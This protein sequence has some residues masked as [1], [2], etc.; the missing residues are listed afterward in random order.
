MCLKKTVFFLICVSLTNC[1]QKPNIVLILADDLGWNDVSYHGSNQIPTPNIDAL[2][3]N[4]IILDRFYTQPACTPS[5]AALLTGQYPI[6]TGF[7]G[8]VIHA[9]ENRYLPHDVKLLPEKL[10]DLGY[11]TN[12]IGKWHLGYAYRNVTPTYRGFDYHFGYWNGVIGYFD[13]IAEDEGLTGFDMRRN[14][15]VMWSTQNQYATELFTTKAK[16]VIMNHNETTP[17][18]LLVSHLAPHAGKRGVVYEVPDEAANNEKFWYI[19][20]DNRRKYA[21]MVDELDKSVGKIIQALFEKGILDNTIILF[22]SDNG[23]Q[24]VGPVQANSGSNWPFRGTKFTAF[25]GGI[26]N[27]AFMYYSRLKQKNVVYDGLMHITDV[28][29][30]LLGAI[31]EN[32]NDLKLD[33]INQWNTLMQNGESNRTEVLINIDEV[34]NWSGIIFDGLKLINGSGSFNQTLEG[35]YGDDGRNS[36]NPPYDPIKVLNSTANK[37]LNSNLTEALILQLRNKTD[38][39]NCRL[40]YDGNNC[41]EGKMCLFDLINDPCETTNVAYLLPDITI[42]LSKRLSLFWNMLVPQKNIPYDPNSNPIYFNNTWTTW[43][44]V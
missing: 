18:F 26:R 27:V 31:G 10:Q 16:E 44:D 25:E 17:L 15:D 34:E 37:A 7:Q 14:F 39:G 41:N 11:N 2:A 21:G 32:T 24:T 5:R 4:G 6:R 22:M 40:D 43:L 28:Y 30:T 3:Y 33:G 12:L 9:G 23:A 8:F 35:F 1:K 20:D 42:E 36:S 29:P 13:H 19:K 38:I